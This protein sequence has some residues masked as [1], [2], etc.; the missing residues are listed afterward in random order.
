[1]CDR[2]CNCREHDSKNR[3]SRHGNVCKDG[4]DGKKGEKG[5]RESCQCLEADCCSSH[6]ETEGCSKYVLD[7][8]QNT[9][10]GQQD[11]KRVYAISN[12]GILVV[13]GFTIHND[14]EC[15]PCALYIRN[16]THKHGLGCW[17]NCTN[18]IDHNHCIQIDFGDYIRSRHWKCS[19]PTMTVSGIQPYE[20]IVI[21]G[22]NTLGALGKRIYSYTNES[23]SCESRDIVLPSFNSTNLTKTGD[24]YQYGTIPFRFLSITCRNASVVLHSITFFL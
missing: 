16:S 4:R 13:Y 15:S 20:Q 7:F 10:C 17:D 3:S 21:Y 24:I 23:G 14:H 8:L 2:S 11:C 22:S 9:S 1:M 19:A 6:H 18:E 5:A 12:R